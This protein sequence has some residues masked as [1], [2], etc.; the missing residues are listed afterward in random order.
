MEKEQT[1]M[2]KE[3]IDPLPLGT[4]KERQEASSSEEISSDKDQL[5]DD[6]DDSSYEPSQWELGR[7]PDRDLRFQFVY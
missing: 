4:E 3:V 6:S 1:T 2:Q 7:E 5:A